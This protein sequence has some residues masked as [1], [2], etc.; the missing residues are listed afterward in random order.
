VTFSPLASAGVIYFFYF[1][2]QNFRPSQYNLGH[3]LTVFRKN[4]GDHCQ[5]SESFCKIA[6]Y[7]HFIAGV[8]FDQ[9]VMWGK[10]R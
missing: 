7:I 4:T 1:H 8:I 5:K 9:K 3:V 2:H 10:I 6:I